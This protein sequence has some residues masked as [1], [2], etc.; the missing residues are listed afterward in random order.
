[1]QNRNRA[2]IVKA[3]NWRRLNWLRHKSLY[4]ITQF[5][6]DT[7]RLYIIFPVLSTALRHKNYTKTCAFFVQYPQF[8]EG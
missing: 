5:C 3:T 4:K 1:V 8:W 6:K 2:I 7:Q